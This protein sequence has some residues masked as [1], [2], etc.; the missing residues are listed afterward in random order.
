MVLIEMHDNVFLFFALKQRKET[1][2]NSSQFNAVWSLL[3]I[4]ANEFAVGTFFE[5]E[6][7]NVV[8]STA[9]YSKILQALCSVWLSLKPKIFSTMTEQGAG[10]TCRNGNFNI[11]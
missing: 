3:E 6:K 7:C 8:N 11:P 1:K 9:C 5:I 4:S 2:E 10:I